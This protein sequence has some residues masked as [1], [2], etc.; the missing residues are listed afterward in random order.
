MHEYFTTENFG[1]YRPTREL[2]S[3]EEKH[4]RLLLQQTTRRI[5]DRFETGLLW[6][7][8]PEMLSRK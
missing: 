2:Q 3:D 6:K 5:G 1:V 7:R 4:A 8:I